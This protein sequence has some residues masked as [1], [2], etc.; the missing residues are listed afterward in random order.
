MQLTDASTDLHFK[1][2]KNN[3]LLHFLN[4][5]FTFEKNPNPCYTTGK[6]HLQWNS[7]F[8][9]FK[10]NQQCFC[11]NATFYQ[12]DPL[13]DSSVFFLAQMKALLPTALSMYFFCKVLVVPHTSS[14]LAR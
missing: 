6:S 11:Q 4:K 2:Y 10:Q 3:V 14:S 8:G 5:V 13:N 12:N 1:K 7:Q 9:E